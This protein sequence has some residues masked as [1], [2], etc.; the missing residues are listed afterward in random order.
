[1]TKWEGDAI[2][3]LDGLHFVVVWTLNKYCKYPDIELARKCR[4][5]LLQISE[6]LIVKKKKV[7]NR[8]HVQYCCSYRICS[9][10]FS[11]VFCMIP[12]R[13][14]PLIAGRDQVNSAL[15]DVA[16]RA[17]TT[18]ARISR[19]AG[20]AGLKRLPQYTM[21]PPSSLQNFSNLHVQLCIAPSN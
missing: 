15:W 10:V 13:I 9:A 5:S 16:W 14:R 20:L 7:D 2:S 4:Y 11:F 8:M 17:G 21:P 19:S 3:M 18:L 6:L 1:M 12:K